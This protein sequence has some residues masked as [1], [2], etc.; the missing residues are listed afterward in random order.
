MS[1][2]SISSCVTAGSGSCQSSVSA[3]DLR[4]EV[5]GDRAHVAVGQL[6]PRAGEGVRELVRVLQEPPRDRL[7][8]RVEPQRE[9]GRQ[10]RRG[11]ALRRVVR[12]GDGAGARAVLRLPL[13]RAGR[14]LG[15]LP[16][17]PE[18][19]LEEAVVPRGRRV[20][21]RTLEP[22]G[23][24]VAALAGAEGVPPAQA[25]LLDARRPRARRRRGRRVPAP[26]VLPK[27][28]PPA[29]SATVSSSFIAMR[30]NVSRMSRAAAIGSGLPFGPS[31]LT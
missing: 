5:A 16:L 9:V 11:V 19:D 4:A 7:V 23:D 26:W 6:E 30:R 24:R 22:A 18:Q 17:V 20:G 28:W 1:A 25:L 31:G 8:D 10:H 21:P 12:V 2:A 27:V 29:I 13:V 14:A 15:Q 3:R